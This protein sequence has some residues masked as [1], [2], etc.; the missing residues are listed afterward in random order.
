M[1]QAVILVLNSNT[2]D[3]LIVLRIVFCP[4]GTVFNF[5]PMDKI[6]DLSKLKAFADDK[7]NVTE[8]LKFVLGRVEN[9]V[10][11]RENAGY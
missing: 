5:S 8:K 2:T 4:K 3:T 6:L 10:G 7:K 9:T 11:K 1:T